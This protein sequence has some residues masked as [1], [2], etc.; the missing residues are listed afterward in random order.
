VLNAWFRAQA[1]QTS[2]VKCRIG[3]MAAG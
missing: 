3:A 2:N 1:S